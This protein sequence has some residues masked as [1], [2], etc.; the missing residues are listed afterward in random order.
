MYLQFGMICHTLQSA[1]QASPFMLQLSQSLLSIMSLLLQMAIQALACSELPVHLFQLGIVSAEVP[2]QQHALQF[3]LLQAM[4]C[5]LCTLFGLLLRPGLL[6][7]A[8]KDRERCSAV[9]PVLQGVC[10]PA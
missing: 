9:V 4:L 1:M 2:A 3:E 5:T 6:C 10:L 7:P 8:G